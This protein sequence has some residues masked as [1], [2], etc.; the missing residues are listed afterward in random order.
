[1]AK[2]TNKFWRRGRIYNILIA[3]VLLCY[4]ALSSDI[5][6]FYL[7]FNKPLGLQIKAP[8]KRSQCDTM[9]PFRPEGLLFVIPLVDP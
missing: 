6:N 2:I 9:V 5:L 1:M 7:F 8:L 4:N 3:I